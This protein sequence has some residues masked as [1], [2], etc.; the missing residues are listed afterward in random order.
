MTF[1][2][3]RFKC[4]NFNKLERFESKYINSISIKVLNK[5]IIF[6]LNIDFKIKGF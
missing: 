2:L 5:S 3:K 6:N 1:I 4:L